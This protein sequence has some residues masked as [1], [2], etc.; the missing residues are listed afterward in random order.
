MAAPAMGVISVTTSDLFNDLDGST[1]GT[2]SFAQ[3]ASADATFMVALYGRRLASANPTITY[4]VGGAGTVVNPSTY[5]N[6]DSGTIGSNPDED[7]SDIFAAVFVLDVGSVGS[8]N[9]DIGW[10]SG[11]SNTT[12]DIFQLTGATGGSFLTDTDSSPDTG[13]LSFDLGAVPETGSFGLLVAASQ[14][15]TDGSYSITSNSNPVASGTSTDQGGYTVIDF[16]DQSGSLNQA[17]DLEYTGKTTN[18]A[19]ALI[20]LQPVPEP[21]T[22]AIFAG[23]GALGLVCWR[24]HRRA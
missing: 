1:S 17:Y 24:R 15:N 5:I 4:D 6:F 22:Y 12:L 23:L 16:F 20:A 18:F 10:N 13:L 8:A 7:T 3:Q 21:S 2:F 9:V 11:S 14:S 19:G